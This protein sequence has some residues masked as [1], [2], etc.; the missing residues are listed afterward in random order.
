MFDNYAWSAEDIFEIMEAANTAKAQQFAQ[1][2]C[3]LDHKIG[4]TDVRLVLQEAQRR[5]ASRRAV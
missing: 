2:R 4:L 3:E 5:L 1:L